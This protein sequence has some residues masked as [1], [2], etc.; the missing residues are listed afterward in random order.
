[1][2]TSI[3]AKADWLITG[4]SDLLD[5]RNTYNIITPHEFVE[6]YQILQ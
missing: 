6:K 4:D 1:L 5:L 3:A 2:A